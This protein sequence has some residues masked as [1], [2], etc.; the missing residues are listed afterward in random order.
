MTATSMEGWHGWD[1]YARYYDWENARTFGRRDVRFW[2]RL[3]S[4]VQGRTLELGCGTGRVSAPLARTGIPVIGIDRSAEMLSRARQRLRRQQSAGARLV[5][6]D[7]RAL[8]FTMAFDLVI[9][10][11]GILQSLVRDEDLIATLQSV[12]RVTTAGA[13]FGIDL[14]PDV[15]RW[16][17]YHRKVTLRARR[18]RSGPIVTLVESVRQNRVE[19]LTIFDQE[20]IEVRRCRA[21]LVNRFSIVFRTV[22]VPELADRLE[23]AGFAVEAV[24][25]DYAGRPWDPRAEVWVI[26]AR[27]R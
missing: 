8:P 14:V 26:L 18:G 6:G 5:R 13:L 11:Y 21:P 2:Q 22:S 12:A 4:E 24:L 3:A 9:A 17:Q 1:A 7:I 25:G 10:P 27:R 20:F 16:A 15:P 23:G 19:R